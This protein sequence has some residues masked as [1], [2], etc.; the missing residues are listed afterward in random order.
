[1]KFFKRFIVAIYV[2]LGAFTVAVLVLNVAGV[3]IQ[4]TLIAGVTAGVGVESIVG[5]IMKVQETKAEGKQARKNAE[6]GIKP[7]N[8]GV[9]VNVDASNSNSGRYE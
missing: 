5:G 3:Q 7:D 1:M 6:A 2:F 8:S 9:N 4:D